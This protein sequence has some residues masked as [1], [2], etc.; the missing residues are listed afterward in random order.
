[1]RNLYVSAQRSRPLA[2]PRASVYL[3]QRL[4]RT[5][6]KIGWAL[7]PQKRVRQLPE[8]ESRQLDLR[9]SSVLW[10][11]S[12]YRAEQVERSMQ[13]SLG[14]YRAQAE[15]RGD[16]YSEWF[17]GNA[18]HIAV[19]L[20]GQIPIDAQAGARG[21]LLP[22]E[23]VMDLD[24]AHDE[25]PTPGPGPLE[26]W[27]ALED[28]WLRTA[29]SRAVTVKAGNARHQIVI[30]RFRSD[31]EALTD[32]LRWPLLNLDTYRWRQDECSGNF[33]TF[34][35]YEDQDLVCTLSSFRV[36]EGWV[37]GADLVCLVRAFLLRLR[38]MPNRWSLR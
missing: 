21:K 12:R 7:D 29:Q 11:P 38:E 17:D 26:V 13:K 32:E 14:P 27:W 36:I 34:L 8:F 3:L 35:N 10:L 30:H 28:L 19:R 5:R 31:C 16:G 25:I 1:M 9:R 6:F 2:S 4:D 18:H 20:L 33:V 24:A 22:L 23:V 37:D 15:H